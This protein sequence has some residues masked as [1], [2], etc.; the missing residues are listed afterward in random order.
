MLKGRRV[1]TFTAGTVLIVFGILFLLRLVLPAINFS[2]IA[3][4]W[5]IILI[6]LGAEILIAYMVN[7]EE[8]MRYDTG[9]IFLVV[10]LSF[11]SMGMAVVEL[12]IK[13]GINGKYITF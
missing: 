7:K 10:V 4:L 6:L 8:K 2:I 9:A 1:G 5:P 12:A 13:Y 11:F 3:S